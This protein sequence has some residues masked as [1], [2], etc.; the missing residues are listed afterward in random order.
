MG[1]KESKK[2]TVIDAAIVDGSAHMMNLFMSLQNTGMFSTERGGS[3]LDGPPWSRCY[4]TSDGLWM[5]VQ[6]LEPKFYQEFLEKMGLSEDPLFQN[7]LNT[8]NWPEM[9]IT[10]EAMFLEKS[11]AEWVN[12]FDHS[13]ACVGPVLDPISSM[14]DPHLSHRE[15]WVEKDGLIQAAPSPRFG[16]ESN[17]EIGKVP[18]RGE[19]MQEILSEISNEKL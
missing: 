16:K 13:D 6:C 4:K 7:Q 19:H 11:L 14:K 9:I 15:T 1:S 18:E 10:L 8:E 3:L 12:K 2:G 5:S 17:Q